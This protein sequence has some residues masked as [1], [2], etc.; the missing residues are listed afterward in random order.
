MS[1]TFKPMLAPN[2]QV[3]GKTVEEQANNFPI[4]PLMASNKYDGIRC[5]FTG[6]QMLTRSLKGVPSTY[7]R[8]KFI[9]I[10]EYTGQ[11]NLILDG[12]MYN[13]A[14]PFQLIQSCVM[15]QDHTTKEAEKK[16]AIL[17]EELGV[18]VTREDALA[19]MKFY[20]FD[21]VKDEQYQTP[22]V[23][24]AQLAKASAMIFNNVVVV[25][26]LLVRTP[27]D[28]VKQF[29]S[30][31]DA[32]FE[33]LI[34]RTPDSYYKRNRGTL[35]EKL[36]FKLKPYVTFDAKIIGVVEGTVVR[37]GAEKK[38]NELGN[39]VTSKKKADRLPGGYACDFVVN[40]KNS[41]AD[42]ETKELRVSIAMKMP[43]KIEVWKNKDQYIG[44]WIEYKG[45]LIG[46]KDLP[47]HPVFL[48]FRDDKE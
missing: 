26:N 36:I 38:I 35:N 3:P 45:L 13:P 27:E 28:I 32:G 21:A 18:S 11:Y 31:L 15:T 42:T 25:E 30:A 1:K 44:R 4:F 8:K 34:L 40:H 7:L 2:E 24:R 46:A 41:D 14:I 47:R 20:I 39:S 23:D 29:N 37:S 33:G 9:D 16:W 17:C 22:F 19:G 6:G 48:R 5:L 43:E 12:E 10:A